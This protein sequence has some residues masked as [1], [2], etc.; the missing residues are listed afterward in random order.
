M[1]YKTFFHE[2]FTNLWYKIGQPFV[3][4]G[5][6]LGIACGIAYLVLVKPKYGIPIAVAIIILVLFINL[7]NYIYDEIYQPAKLKAIDV[8]LQPLFE[9]RA[10]QLIHS[11]AMIWPV[12]GL[13]QH[14]IMPQFIDLA[15][16]QY[17]FTVTLERYKSNISYILLRAGLCVDRV[18]F[19][20]SIDLI[21]KTDEHGKDE[22]I[23]AV[24]KEGK[25]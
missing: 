17:N 24:K 18:A 11:L 3:G 12:I 9:L 5:T 15:R 2:F 8:K 20:E 4:I 16:Q 23:V 13:Y 19:E 14:K 6:L 25:L 7:V 22:F 21:C 10:S 1:D